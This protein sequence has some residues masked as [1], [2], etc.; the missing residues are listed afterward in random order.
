[1]AREAIITFY[2]IIACYNSNNNDNSYSSNVGSPLEPSSYFCR[3]NLFC[4]D[5]PLLHIELY[6]AICFCIYHKSAVSM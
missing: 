2:T 6:C 1:M 3:P 5:T 4:V